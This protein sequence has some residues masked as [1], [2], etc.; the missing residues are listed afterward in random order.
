MNDL[1][2]ILQLWRELE[3]AGADYVLAT[4]VGVE[5]SSYRRP[6]TH[7]L[8]AQD[9]R[10]AGT[11]S[12]GCLE[13]E[14]ARKAWWLT[15][16]GPVIES[17]STADDDGDRP[18]GSGCG[19]VVHLLLERKQTAGLLL[20]AL[21]LAFNARAAL[22]VATVLEGPHMGRRAFAGLPT[23]N[24]P[25]STGSLND[26]GDLELG[27]LAASAFKNSTAGETR[28]ALNGTE[29]RVWANCCAA[30]T[31]LWI[32]SAGDDAKPLARM[33]R[34]LGW[35]VAVLDGRSNLATPARFPEAHEVRAVSMENLTG[36]SPQLNALATDAVVVMT[37]S[38]EQDSHFL[39]A[40]LGLK[41]APAYVG[42]LGPQRRTRELLI[43]AA[44]LLGVK[45]SSNRIDRWMA[46]M[47]APT[48]L[49]L[50]ADTPAAIALAILGE[51][52]KITAG[53]TALPLRDVRGSAQP[54]A[55]PPT[56]NRAE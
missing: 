26:V 4:I 39:A 19:G 43:E 16:A 41:T 15:A 14:V 38:F 49:D 52:Q 44:R 20:A 25:A 23:G 22:G 50:G 45:A 36:A 34:E 51:I 17:Y 42:V 12:G 46:A 55:C 53:A 3:S 33:A 9:G 28:I 32:C 27:D 54:V 6:G 18:Y 21:D 37:H 30:R 47:H 13:A 40:V 5:G 56:H 24:L 8:L 2:G 1:E 48:G 11:V 29:T 31:G 7:M 10:R 35:F